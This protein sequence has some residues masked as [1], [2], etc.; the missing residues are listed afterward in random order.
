MALCL[1]IWSNVSFVYL[2][3]SSS[4]NLFH[5]SLPKEI[6]F[7]FLNF[8]PNNKIIISLSGLDTI[9]LLS[10]SIDTILPL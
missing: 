5:S 2:L 8:S 7:W 4:N 9:N 6:R 1:I 10:C 3:W